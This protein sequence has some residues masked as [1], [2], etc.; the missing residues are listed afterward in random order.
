MKSESRVFNSV[1]N[2]MIGFGGQLIQMVLAFVSRAIFIRALSSEYLGINGLFT[3]ILALLSLAELGVG[4]AIIYTLYKPIADEDVERI[5]VL[6]NFY[7]KCYITIGLTILVMGLGLTCFLDVL[8]KDTPT[9]H[10]S[11]YVIYLFYLFN[12]VITYFYS[13]KSA[14]IVANQ[15]QYIVT[16]RTQLMHIIQ[17]FG[18]LVILI[19]TKNFMLYLTVQSLCVLTYNIVISRTA[20]K[21]YPYLREKTS[22]TLAPEEKSL[23]KKNVYSLMLLKIG[24]TLVNNTDNLII[25]A[26][27]GL[28]PLGL[29]SNYTLIMN[30]INSIVTQVFTAIT[31]SV[32]NLNV[33]ADKERR[34]SI[35]KVINLLNFYFYGIAAI[36]LS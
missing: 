32:G 19:V 21:M 13:Y 18:Q 35:F 15:K 26:L 4:S 6:M 5:K 8:I 27:I 20:D 36:G 31:A 7:K 16:M 34:Y 30:A 1:R 25:S 12:T 14:L 28:G 10:E 3:N 24:G 17:T 22:E 33:T 2:V 9:I 29:V 11:I 23:M